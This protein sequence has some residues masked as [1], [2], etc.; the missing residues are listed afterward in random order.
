M[1]FF[2]FFATVQFQ[3]LDNGEPLKVSKTVIK[4]VTCKNGVS[5]IETTRDHKVSLLFCPVMSRIQSDAEAA[6][7]CIKGKGLCSPT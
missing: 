1:V 4:K 3:K 6:I 5:F 2:L 7:A